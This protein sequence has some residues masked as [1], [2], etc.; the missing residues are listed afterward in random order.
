MHKLL[1][2]QLK[3]VLGVEEAQL[4]ALL[5][6]LQALAKTQPAST[7]AT[8]ALGNLEK[9][10]QR[11]DE[12]Y[13]QSDRDLDLRAR[14][15]ELSSVELSATNS[16]LRDELDSRTRAMDSLR[17]TA[18][19]L[20]VS[21][22]ADEAAPV[23]DSL[24]GLSV[25]MANLVK[26]KE[27]SQKDL[28]FALADLANQKF[29]LD[30]HAIVSITDVEGNII[31]AND[32]MCHISGYA[33]EELIGQNHRIM[34]SGVQHRSFFANL[35]STI[36]QGKVWHG[37]ICNKTKSGALYWV[38]ATMVPLRDDA[39]KPTMYIAIRTEITE[40][41]RMESTIKAAEARLRHIT[42]TLPG[43]VFQLHVGSDS[44]KYIFVSDR[45]QEVRGVTRAELLADSNVTT[46]QI[47]PEDRERVREGIRSAAQKREVWLDEYR[48]RLPDGSLHWIRGEMS[49]EPDLAR[50]GGT[51]FTGIWQDVTQ[52]KEADA[53]L[54]E[55][56]ENIPVAV[57]QYYFGVDRVF[58]IPFISQAVFSMSGVRPEEM[59]VDSNALLQCVHPE[60]HKT[61]VDSLS[62]CL[63]SAQHWSIDFRL[64]HAQSKETVWVHGESQPRHLANGKM[65]WNGYLADISSAKRI[66]EE[67]QK[68]K[69]GAES[70]NRAKSEFLAN[71]SHEIRTPMNGVIGM[72][73][74]LMDTQLDAEQ[75]EYLGI[76][77][78]SSEALLRVI[79]DIL[80]FSKIEAGK[81]QIEIIPF[82]LGR[83]VGDALKTLALR[84]H[85]KGLELVCD[86]APD[87][88]MM[89]MGDPGRL[90]QI[91]VNIIGNSIKFTEKGEIVVRVE[92]AGRASDTALMHFAISD[93]GIGIPQHKLSSIFDAFS[94]ED[95]STTRK[96]GGTGL[97]LTIC[98]RLAEAMGGRIWV[99]SQVG[100]GS[101]FH[102]T[103]HLAPDPA[104]AEGPV[105][106]SR[107]DGQRVL[108][109]DDNAVNRTV[110]VR[111]LESVG[112]QTA[113]AASGDEALAML[114][115]DSVTRL[116]YQLVI[117]DGQM[118]G[119]DGYATAERI[120][121]LP[122][123]EK[124]P[125]VM[126]SSAGV[127]GDAQRS[128]DTGIS[129]YL[130]KPLA[131]DELL[132]LLARVLRPHI[133]RNEK[134]VTRH[135]LKDEQAPLKLLL[136]EDHPVNQKLAVTL[137]QRWG[138]T[139]Q[140]ADNGKIAVDLVAQESFDIILMDMMMPVMDGLE[141]TRNIRNYQKT[142]HTP[143]IAM[144]ANAMETD[145]QKCLEAGMDDFI[146]KPIKAQELKDKL[147]RY[148]SAPVSPSG[149]AP[150]MADAA[151][152]ASTT[153]RASVFDYASALAAQDQEIVDIVA[154]PFVRQWP[155]ELQKIQSALAQ[156]DMRSV[157]HAAHALK[158]TLAI[159]GAAPAS[160][161]AL[162][163]EGFAQSGDA[164]GVTALM[165]PFTAEVEQF[166]SV[167]PRGGAE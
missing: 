106:T 66:S 24:E 132:Q 68:A 140:V 97:G 75:R 114:S 92:R 70:A 53:R 44:M 38:D 89:V 123:Y 135:T 64:V 160:G 85:A 84:T 28:Q 153:Q 13:E 16:R 33:R 141:A 32:K 100:K 167:M 9:F 144:T 102:F 129:G 156:G 12:A 157:L 159:F 113:Q 128:R 4:P 18:R 2:R 21:V 60:D 121:T 149:H 124:T 50:D 110:V 3:R 154:R 39:G 76:V 55:V 42:N 115:Q 36:V 86:I 111:A 112:A 43:V 147:L 72:T 108:V 94:Q 117:L 118:P 8:Q 40:R 11:I 56:T 58:K 91:L 15:L 23:D 163:I 30:Q 51:V 164:T 143:I 139:V 80:D 107:F 150:L 166:L 49:P 17:A 122:G 69:E 46:R 136:V 151:L 127:K 77:K 34:N 74:L 48:V 59:M 5:A 125:L 26:Q 103:L 27:E 62:Q 109:V 35:W 45:V 120:H 87:V 37:E 29:A 148:S 130:S 22:D 14:S 146:S 88:P 165:E 131:R 138:H 145:R 78:S 57:F 99:E 105:P 6:E 116:T 65:V 67:L 10:L 101:V 71:M 142:D 31:Y 95:S 98:A 161:L 137:L 54:R 1:A 155:S 93:T 20:M 82:N 158:G 162:R 96:Y 81:L 47:E 61:V 73:E 79:N 119:M 133:G 25:L 134:L 63:D 41:K 19:N 126:L 7:Q 83:C 104:A 90:R 152:M 52:I